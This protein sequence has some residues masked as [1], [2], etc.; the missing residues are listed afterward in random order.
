MNKQIQDEENEF[1]FEA[2]L[3]ATLSNFEVRKQG[4]IPLLKL[5]EKEIQCKTW[6]L[7]ILEAGCGSGVDSYLLKQWNPNKLEVFALDIDLNSIKTVQW[8]RKYFQYPIKLIQT[9]LY[10]MPFLNEAFDLIFSQGVLEHFKNPNPLMQEQ[11][12][13]LKSD[14]TLIID[15]PQKYSPYTIGKYLDKKRGKWKIGYETQYSYHELVK[16]GMAHGLKAVHSLGYGHNRLFRFLRNPYRIL[17]KYRIIP[18]G[19]FP[20][21]RYVDRVLERFWER[22]DWTLGRYF[23]TSVVVSFKRV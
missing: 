8:W 9:N 12:R 5:I 22:L 6:P 13:I 2:L 19:L 1:S 3:K 14:G 18:H 23:A 17:Q 15:V 4:N 7:K 21:F 11:I 20:S 16:L 10:S